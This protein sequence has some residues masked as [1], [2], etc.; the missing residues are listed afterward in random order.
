[1]INMDTNNKQLMQ[2][3]PFYIIPEVEGNVIF[4]SKSSTLRLRATAAGQIVE[5]ILPLL[6]GTR[7]RN[8]IIE[9]LAPA[10]SPER[11][12]ALLDQL[13][14][15]GFVTAAEAPPETIPDALAVRLESMRRHLAGEENAGWKAVAQLREAHVAIVNQGSMSAALL[16]N[17]LHAGIG[18]ITMLGGGKVTELEASRVQFVNEADVGRPWG[19]VLAERVPFAK[20]DARFQYQAAVPDED[21]AWDAALRGV[22]MV[23]AVVDGPSY[24]KPSLASLNRAALRARTPWIL[25]GN[26]QKIGLAVGPTFVP[27]STPCL[28]CF[29]TRLKSNLG[30]LQMMELLEQYAGRGGKQVEFGEIAPGVD[31]AANLAC[32]EIIDTLVEGRL[33]KTA[34]KLLTVDLV[35]YGLSLHNVLRLP[36]CPVCRPGAKSVN[37]RIWA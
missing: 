25:V 2:A 20:F 12:A 6:D 21:E 23:A 1:M 19:E 28:T 17:L 3:V 9:E 36:R 16:L 37:T 31:V 8:G 14:K 5:S 11:T 27:G 24:F 29:E 26:V 30:N 7:S 18:A 35:S 22:S 32:L 15:H 13:R 34:G 10:L 4:H 33:A